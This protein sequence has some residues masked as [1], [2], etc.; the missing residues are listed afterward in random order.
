[1]INDNDQST[2]IDNGQE[3]EPS[4]PINKPEEVPDSNDEKIDEDFPGYPHYPAKVDILHASNNN[5]K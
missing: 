4:K 1:M 3:N 2:E 5:G